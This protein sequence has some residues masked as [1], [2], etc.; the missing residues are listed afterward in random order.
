MSDQE[1]PK[2]ALYTFA[3]NIVHLTAFSKLYNFTG[4]YKP[5]IK[6]SERHKLQKRSERV[7]RFCG[8]SAD[9]T[10]FKNKPH[11][12]SRLFGNNNGTSDYECDKCNS[13]FSKFETNTA[14]F[15]GINRTIYSLGKE[16]VPTYKAPDGSIEAREKT[17]FDQQVVEISAKMP[18]FI[19]AVD[20]TG[21]IEMEFVSNSYIPLMVYKSLLKI[22]LTILP[23][24]LFKKYRLANLFLM[25]DLNSDH[26]AHHAK[27]IFKCKLGG[28]VPVPYA[29]VFSKKSQDPYLPTHIFQLYYQESCIQFHIPY[30]SDD[31]QLEEGQSMQLTMCPPLMITNALLDGRSDYEI[32][33]LSSNEKIKSESKKMYLEFDKEQM[34]ETIPV[35]VNTGKVA[36]RPFDPDKVVKVYFS[37]NTP[38]DFS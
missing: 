5:T 36:G 12:I 27:N 10:T 20:S 35:D 18:G 6:S 30:N 25:H 13:H 16:T 23:D 7:C 26:F 14:D 33:D 17:M 34:K 38:T 37:R 11:I 32:L 31:E 29:I 24:D 4:L 21:K 9:K 15:L 19:N 22:A 28:E 8:M 1:E 3:G 2:L